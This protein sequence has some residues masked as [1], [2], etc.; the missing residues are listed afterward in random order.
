MDTHDGIRRM[1]ITRMWYETEY[2][3]QYSLSLAIL[4]A[5]HVVL[6]PGLASYVM[7]DITAR[8]TGRGGGQLRVLHRV[9]TAGFPRRLELPLAVDK[10]S[11]ASVLPL[12]TY[13]PF[14]RGAFYHVHTLSTEYGTV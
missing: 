3:M 12:F 13:P 6:S 11:R 9:F 14:F 2:L 5:A 4:P 1:L 7:L 8:S 10:N